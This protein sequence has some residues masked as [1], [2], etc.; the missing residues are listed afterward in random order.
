MYSAFKDDVRP[1]YVQYWKNQME[2]GLKNKIMEAGVA[3]PLLPWAHESFAGYE[4][5]E[6]SYYPDCDNAHAP[7]KIASLCRSQGKGPN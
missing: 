7:N 4:G 6:V 2:A 3:W 5:N 1:E